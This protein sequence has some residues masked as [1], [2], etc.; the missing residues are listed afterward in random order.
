MFAKKR[1]IS[2]L[3][4]EIQCKRLNTQMTFDYIFSGIYEETSPDILTLQEI[5]PYR[6]LSI[7]APGKEIQV[8]IRFGD[9]SYITK[10]KVK[11]IKGDKVILEVNQ[12]NISDDKRQFYRFHFC[13]EDLGVF[14]LV[15]N[16]TVISK[17]ICIYELS[18]TGIGLYVPTDVS[19]KVGS[20]YNLVEKK[21][22]INFTIQVIHVKNAGRFN[23]VGNKI[24][25]SNINL[26]KYILQ[27]YI[28]VSEKLITG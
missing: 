11:E 4:I 8:Y 19:L 18:K 1:H 10:G 22:N 9:S 23:I 21:K 24:K 25:K 13:C 15:E 27:E 16:S 26:L 14:S 20:T 28:K 12:N 3:P 5:N 6:T 7:L 2:V 17:E